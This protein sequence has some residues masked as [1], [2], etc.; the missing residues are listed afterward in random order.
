MVN[1]KGN[2]WSPCLRPL[3]AKK[4]RDGK[5]FTK[6]EN[7]VVEIHSVIHPPP[8]TKAQSA[9]HVV[10]EIPIHVIICLFK[11]ILKNSFLLFIFL[12]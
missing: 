3:E 11:I 10:Y 8:A 6:V 2:N 4:S 5:Q 9:Q 1:K 12:P 7:E